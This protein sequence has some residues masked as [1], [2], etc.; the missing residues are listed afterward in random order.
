MQADRQF[1]NED[2]ETLSP[3]GMQALQWRRLKKQLQYNFENSFYYRQEKFQKAGLTPDD[4]QTFE[5]FRKIP[6]M[7]KDEHRWIQTESMRKFGH[8][9]GL[10]TCAPREKIV[11][12]N[13]TSGTTGQPT[14]YTL[15]GND[16]KVLNEMHCRKYWRTGLRPGHI[17]LQALSLS[18]FTGGLPL[19]DGLQAMGLC[20]VPVGIEGGT[21]RVLDFALLTKPDVLIATPSFGEYLIEQ[22][23]KLIGKDAREL[24]IR[25]FYCAGEPGAGIPSLRNKLQ[26]GFGAK[27][28]DHTG[29][30]HA[31]HGISCETEPYPGMHFVSGD[32]CVL[33]LVDPKT[34]DPIEINH[35]AMGEM[36]FSFIG[37][38]GG[39]FMRYALG[40]LIQIFSEPC[41]CGWPEMR[42]KIL[43]RAD[44]MLIIKGVNLYPAALKG[45]VGEL[46]PRTSGALR[47]VLEQPGPLVKPP[48]KIRIEYG[49][50]DISAEDMHKLKTELTQLI[51]DR[52]RVSPDIELVPPFSLPRESGKISLIEIK[53]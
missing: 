28:F 22:A 30:G 6:L 38:E 37:W 49:F 32:H 24:G 53:T 5:D 2:V 23:P 46:E 15:T 14:L 45:L 20:V 27:V 4:I 33:E 34:K 8:P 11:R 18:M 29:G 40:D 35:G 17:V 3:E 19:S 13:S 1:W 31:F 7:T 10:I 12:I 21:R 48:L 36:V 51:K 43:G 9:Y 26:E 50:K 47:I 25:W 41:G 39:P 52:L 42:F 44:D 16:I